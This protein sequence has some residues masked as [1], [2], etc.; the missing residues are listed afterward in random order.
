MD[1]ELDRIASLS[2]SMAKFWARAHGWAPSVAADSLSAARL[3]WLASFSRTLRARVEE[4]QSNPNEPA[5]LILAWA[6]LRTL[7]E[8]NLKFYLTVFLDTY[9]R[10]PEAHKDRQSGQVVLPKDLRLEQIRHFLKKRGLLPMQ[11]AFIE[12]VQNRGNAIHAFSDKP[13]GRAGEYL[14][15]IPLYREFLEDIETS[16][17]YPDE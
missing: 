13:I 4:V 14:E 17:P 2:A 16:F 10:E 9:L 15:Q 11:E 1:D 5:D 6:H 3:D 8:G 7:V 12:R